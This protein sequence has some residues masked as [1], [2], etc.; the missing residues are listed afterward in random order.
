M[1]V[2]NSEFFFSGIFVVLVGIFFTVLIACQ[3]P[4]ELATCNYEPNNPRNLVA[5]IVVIGGFLMSMGLAKNS[6]MIYSNLKCP[7][8]PRDFIFLTMVLS[9]GLLISIF[10]L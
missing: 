7:M 5:V 4:I 1:R 10:N 3:S 9:I 8:P 6:K 2:A